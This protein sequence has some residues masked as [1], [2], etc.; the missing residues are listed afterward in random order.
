VDRLPAVAPPLLLVALLA[1]CEEGAPNQPIERVNAVRADPPRLARPEDF[2]DV[3][4]Q[5]EKARIFHYPKLAGAAPSADGRWRWINVWATWC[6]PCVEEI[7]MLVEWQ[8]QM[9]RSKAG[10]DLVLVSLDTD[11]ATVDRFRKQHPMTPP[12]LR[13]K[14]PDRAETWVI[15]LGLDRGATLPIHVLVDPKGAIRCARTG[16]VDHGDQAVVQRILTAP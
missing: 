8:A 1:A 12:S 14:D 13:L 9:A 11:D 16:R 5:G 6:I 7:P 2:C 4:A 10:F 15:S 3:V